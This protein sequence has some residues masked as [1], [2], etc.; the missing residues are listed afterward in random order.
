[1]IFGSSTSILP[2]LKSLCLSILNQAI[3]EHSK[4]KVLPVPVGDSK[5]A[6]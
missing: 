4:D 6:F 3:A 2:A 1:M 5:S